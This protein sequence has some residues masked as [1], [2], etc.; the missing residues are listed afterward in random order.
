MNIHDPEIRHARRS[1][2]A[3][4][5]PRARS[6][7]GRTRRR[8]CA[9]RCA[10]SCSR[11]GAGEPNLPVYDT[12]GP[13]T[14]P[15]VEIDVEKGLARART[16]WV[17]ERGGVEEY[18]GRDDQARGQRQRRRQAPRARLPDREPAAARRSTATRSRSSNS[19]APASSPRR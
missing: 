1:P 7:R 14:D 15:N 13:Y 12:T 8:T 11:E 17:K 18:D 4:C 2:P 19:P 16:D 6:I 5:R 10:R 9:C 3:R